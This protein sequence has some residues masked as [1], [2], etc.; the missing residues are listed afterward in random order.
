MGKAM[1]ESTTTGPDSPALTLGFEDIGLR[2]GAPLF[3][4][5][6]EAGAAQTRYPV[7]YIG[8]IKGKSLLVTLPLVNGKGLWMQNG[9]TFVFHVVQGM[10]VYAFTC[11][12][13]RPR[14]SPYPYVHFSYP[15][16]IDARQVRKSY[17]VRMRLPVSVARGE[18]RS[19]AL[20]LDLSM[21]GALLDAPAG[22]WQEED[23]LSI[24]LP[25]ALEEASSQLN[26]PATVR[27]CEE[28][29]GRAHYGVEFAELPQNEALLLH[30]YI[31]HAIATRLG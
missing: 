8:A 24:V 29:G 25:V 21:T 17:R 19:E 10:Y 18:E 31:D 1:S 15:T 13:L 27:N 6:Q 4:R 23:A 20:L 2:V 22:I 30:Y 11:Q 16:R 9:Q 5:C 12:V 14:S 26:L 28:K 3:M 7:E